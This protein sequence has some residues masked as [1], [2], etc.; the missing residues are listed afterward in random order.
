MHFIMFVYIIQCVPN[1][2]TISLPVALPERPEVF[3]IYLICR[4]MRKLYI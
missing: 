3:I 2:K 1:L 4:P